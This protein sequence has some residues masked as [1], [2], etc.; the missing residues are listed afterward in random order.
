MITA[1]REKSGIIVC[2]G[3]G[4]YLGQGREGRSKEP[5]IFRQGAAHLKAL[6]C[7]QYDEA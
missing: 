5:A 6:M 4:V 3:V 1:V 2:V 7:E